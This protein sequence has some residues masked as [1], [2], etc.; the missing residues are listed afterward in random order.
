VPSDLSA[1]VRKVAK[2]GL[3]VEEKPQHSTPSVDLIAIW[4]IKRPA[5]QPQCWTRLALLVSEPSRLPEVNR[6]L[7]PVPLGECRSRCHGSI[8][9]GACPFLTAPPQIRSHHS[10]GGFGSAIQRSQFR[11]IA[12]DEATAT[13]LL[14]SAAVVVQ[15]DEGS[16]V[17]PVVFGYTGPQK[18]PSSPLHA[19]GTVTNSLH[20][21]EVF[22]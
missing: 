12:S 1:V 21:R 3:H 8:R 16:A 6:R 15:K 19:G 4:F 9:L 20:S 2:L 17:L 11:L 18:R 7:P 22:A 10:T 13:K 14:H 5:P